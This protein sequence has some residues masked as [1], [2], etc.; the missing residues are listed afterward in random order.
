MEKQITV[1]K[2]QGMKKREVKHNAIYSRSILSRSIIIPMNH[3][4]KNVKDVLEKFIISNYEGKCVVE[5]YIKI[6]S[7]KLITYSSGIVQ[8]TNIRFEIV[9]ECYICCPVEGM[10]ISCVAKN[11]TKAGIRGESVE[12][13]P[14]PIVVFVTR[15]HHYMSKKFN[16]VVEGDKFVARII[17]QRFELNDKYVSIIAE[18]VNEV[19]NV[20]VQNKSQPKKPKLKIEN[21]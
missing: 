16:E 21:E 6:N 17:G 10:L 5:G 19:A 11:I 14:S 3:I 1:N 2:T 18:L 20:P 15:D 8:G 9:F 7:V 4:A 13:S 12:E